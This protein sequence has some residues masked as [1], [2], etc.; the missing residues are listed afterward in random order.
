M[1]AE[2][3]RRIDEF[4]VIVAPPVWSAFTHYN[5]GFPHAHVLMIDGVDGEAGPE[6]VPGAA[7][8]RRR[9]ATNRRDHGAKRIPVRIRSPPPLKA[10]TAWPGPTSSEESFE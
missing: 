9:R 2:V 1:A 3:A 10:G 6:F 5:M 7:L 8:E 4:P